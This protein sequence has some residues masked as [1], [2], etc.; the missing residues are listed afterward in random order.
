MKPEEVLVGLFFLVFIFLIVVALAFPLI[1]VP[2]LV[3]TVFLLYR[4]YRWYKKQWEIRVE[5][6]GELVSL[7]PF[8]F[9]RAMATLLSDLGYRKVRV[10]GSSGDLARDIVCEDVYGN[11][12]MVQC[13]RYTS[14]N[15]T[16]PEMQRFI[17]M[18]V[19]EH[20]ADKGIYITTSG[21][22]EPA[23]RLGLKHKIELWDGLK[24]ANLLIEQR[25]LKQKLEQKR[26]SVIYK[27]PAITYKFCPYC[28][29][30]VLS[31]AKFCA[32]CGSS[33]EIG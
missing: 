18:M 24:L 11:V 28:G 12:V 22:T 15:V 29:A 23:R 13:K 32:K 27:K 33:L 4:L 14:Q 8:Q 3:M 2:I 5:T 21:F 1:G 25:K 17:G 26:P 7:T 16:S 19:T 20:K 30:Q 10:T 31:G 9:E 6:L